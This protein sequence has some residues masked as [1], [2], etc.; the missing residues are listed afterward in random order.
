MDPMNFD[1]FQAILRD[2]ERLS[3]YSG[4]VR[5]GGHLWSLTR[6][7]NTVLLHL[8]NY[9]VRCEW[10]GPQSITGWLLYFARGEILIMAIASHPSEFVEELRAAVLR[11]TEDVQHLSVAIRGG[12]AR[13]QAAAQV[14]AAENAIVMADRFLEED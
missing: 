5:W 3:D 14:V 9:T 12:N 8:E 11:A 4:S 13:A 2:P 1:Q 6:S 10:G 7:T